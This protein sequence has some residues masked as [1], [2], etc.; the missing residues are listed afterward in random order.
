MTTTTAFQELAEARHAD[1][2]GVLGP[3][4]EPKGV[5]VRAML[6]TAERVTLLRDGSPPLDMTRRHD[7]GVF[8]ATLSGLE[9][10]P[11]YRL[12]VADNGGGT[13]AI[14]NCG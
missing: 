13:I 3:H 9:E 5:V 8:E 6:P 4:L 14:V 1:P 11:D 10:I 7:G 2:F 12:R